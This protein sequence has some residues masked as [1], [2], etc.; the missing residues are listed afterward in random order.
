MFVVC[1]VNDELG[2]KIMKIKSKNYLVD[3]GSEDKNAKSQV[4]H[5]KKT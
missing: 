4:C 1:L 3:D 2:G 5:K